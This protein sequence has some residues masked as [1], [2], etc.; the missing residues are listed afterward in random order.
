M[1]EVKY[2]MHRACGEVFEQGTNSSDVK[3]EHHRVCEALK[4]DAL[5]GKSWKSNMTED[6]AF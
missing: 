6:E 5:A 2:M 1:P 3:S 4:A